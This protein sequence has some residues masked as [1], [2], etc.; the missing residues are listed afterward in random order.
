MTVL[1]KY[2]VTFTTTSPQKLRAGV[3]VT[4]YTHRYMGQDITAAAGVVVTG[5]DDSVGT[6]PL[7]GTNGPTVRAI[8]DGRKYLEFDGVNDHIKNDTLTAGDFS[9]LVLVARTRS[10]DGAYTVLAAGAQTTIIR[11]GTSGTAMNPGTLM[12]NSTKTDNTWRVIIAT[13]TA[14]EANITVDGVK[15]TGVA[16]NAF[17]NMLRLGADGTPNL[18]STLDVIEVLT[19]PTALSDGDKATIRTSLK[20]AYPTLLT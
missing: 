6:K 14:S 19:Y 18:F 12:T 7:T 1:T 8:A 3:G 13:S 16:G 10:T 17:G 15:T 4:G 5:W 9:T 2:P 11:A 20:A